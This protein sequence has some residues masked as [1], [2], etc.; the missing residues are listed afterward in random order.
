[1]GQAW[2][3]ASTHN[4]ARHRGVLKWAGRCHATFRA[5]RR[6][7][8]RPAGALCAPAPTEPR[9]VASEPRPHPVVPATVPSLPPP[10][11]PASCTPRRPAWP[12]RP[13]CRL[14][15][16]V[17]SRRAAVDGVEL[18]QSLLRR[19][20]PVRGI[21]YGLA[22][23]LQHACACFGCERGAGL[24]C[25]TVGVLQRIARFSMR[26]T[27]ARQHAL[28]CGELREDGRRLSEHRHLKAAPPARRVLLFCAHC[29]PMTATIS[30]PNV[31]VVT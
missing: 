9:A 16:E 24:P 20:G 18:I 22:Y 25:T 12:Q 3:R 30:T 14:M 17:A 10:S 15:P 6:R 2:R 29:E 26:G 23:K 28:H 8:A 19:A 5:T 11:P 27:L 7:C 21:H 13:W 4:W 1:M 31:P